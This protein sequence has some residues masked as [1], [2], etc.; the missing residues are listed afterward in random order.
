MAGLYDGKPGAITFPATLTIAT[1]SFSNPIVITTT[2]PLPA[3]FFLTDFAG[4][5]AQPLVHIYDQTS[6]TPANGIWVA[7]PTGPNTFTIPAAGISLTG[8]GTVQ[9]LYLESAYSVPQDGDPDTSASIA[10]WAQATGDRTQWL[11]AHA[12]GQFK[13]ARREIFQLQAIGVASWSHWAAGAV[14]IGNPVQL[15]GDTA[16]WGTSFGSAISTPSAGPGNTVFAI[17]G[18]VVGDYVSVKLVTSVVVP[19]LHAITLYSS[20][21]PFGSFPAWPADYG[22]VPGAS[23]VCDAAGTGNATNRNITCEGI[24]TNSSSRTGV[25]WVQPVLWPLTND[26]PA[27]ALEGEALLTIDIYRPTG[28]PQ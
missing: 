6:N 16:A 4:N 19:A 7:T 10:S 3:E 20:I 27:V 8:G 11:A 9:P 13:L 15:T 2:T 5:P 26:S 12:V 21:L 28:M 25:V 22:R 17:D 18:V 14:T 23:A 24:V 1:A